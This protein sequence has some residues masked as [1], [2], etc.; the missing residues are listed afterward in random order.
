MSIEKAQLVRSVF[1][2]ILWIGFSIVFFYSGLFFTE[3]LLDTETF[4]GG[5]RWIM[6]LVFPLLVP[7]F[8]I[9]NRRYGCAAGACKTRGHAQRSSSSHFPLA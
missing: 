3:W 7:A 9:V 6:V 2:K 4:A 1:N 8:F 5:W